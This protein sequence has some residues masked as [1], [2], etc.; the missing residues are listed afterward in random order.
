MDKTVTFTGTVCTFT[1][2]KLMREIKPGCT[3]IKKPAAYHHDK[4]PG[5]FLRG[6]VEAPFLGLSFWNY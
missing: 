2:F 6:Y 4:V 5:F 1:S 3:S